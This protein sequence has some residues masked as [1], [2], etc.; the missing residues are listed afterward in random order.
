MPED[1][2]AALN[3]AGV[4]TMA[5]K[6]FDEEKFEDW[7]RTV[8]G[9]NLPTLGAVAFVRRLSFEAEIVL[10]STL[11]SSVEQPGDSSTPKPLPHAERTARMAKLRGQFPG[12]NV[13]GVN[14]PAQALLDECVFHM[15]T[16][17]C[18]T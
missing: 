9:G 3:A 18:V 15:S 17:F 16:G 8:N 5:H 4:R 6:E 12:L 2:L 13:V 7:L 10:T 11:R 14:G 1:V